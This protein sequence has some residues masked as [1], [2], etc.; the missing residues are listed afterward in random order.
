MEKT[1]S[2]KTELSSKN[3]KHVVYSLLSKEI[4]VLKPV[5]SVREIYY[6]EIG[7]YFSVVD[8]LENLVLE[9]YLRKNKF[10]KVILCP[11][12]NSHLVLSR[13]YCPSCDSF[14]VERIMLVMHTPCGH[15]DVLSAFK[16][17]CPTCGELIKS[18]DLELLGEIMECNSCKAR[19]DEPTVK[20]YCL[21]CGIEFTHREA[22][23]EKIFEYE[24]VEEKFKELEETLVKDLVKSFFEEKGFK[25]SSNVTIQGASG[26]K[27]AFS[28]LAIR[29][30]IGLYIDIKLA[31]EESSDIYVRT[32]AKYI[33]VRDVNTVSDVLLI[34]KGYG[35]KENYDSGFKCITFQNIEELREKLSRVYSSLIKSSK[36]AETPE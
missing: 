15:I 30:N 1:S 12:C 28:F 20:H 26:L 8:L 16:E 35:I 17:K 33:D 10:I 21:N 29:N 27:H 31:D 9:G 34:L 4:K 22:I 5:V 25:V 7:D 19:F 23:Y 18:E 6:P 2:V 36:T 11:N 32:Y 13:Y 3:I 14:D 24:I